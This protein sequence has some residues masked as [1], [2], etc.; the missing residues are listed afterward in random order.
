MENTR[1]IQKIGDELNK[2]YPQRF[3]VETAGS[4]QWPFLSSVV[5]RFFETAGISIKDYLS[6]VEKTIIISALRRTEGNQK[7]AADLLGIKHT[8]LNEKI[9][10]HRICFK[11][12]A[13]FREPDRPLIV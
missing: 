5:Q 13:F 9:K 3:P 6:D 12:Q 1:K 11:K 2:T 7:N 8:T 10:R 4:D